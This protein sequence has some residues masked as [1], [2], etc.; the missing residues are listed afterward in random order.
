[1]T[2]ES[3]KR[4]DEI[5]PG[6]LAL[7]YVGDEMS[8]AERSDFEDLLADNQSAREAVAE[9]VQLFAA[10]PLAFDGSAF[11]SSA[12]VAASTEPNREPQDTVQLRQPSLRRTSHIWRRAGWVALGAAACLLVVVGFNSVRRSVVP[13]SQQ[14]L[15]QDSLFGQAGSSDQAFTDLALQW[16][17]IAPKTDSLAM[18]AIPEDSNLTSCSDRNSAT[19]ADEEPP[20]NDETASAEELAAPNWLL[21]AVSPPGTEFFNVPESQ[22]SH[23]TE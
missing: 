2:P 5:D 22:D 7:R 20:E 3:F 23:A 9:A 18:E 4:L 19:D 14:S 17:N 13:N 10:V 1:M 15:L 11:E 21:A 8:P 16:T 6:L 12:R